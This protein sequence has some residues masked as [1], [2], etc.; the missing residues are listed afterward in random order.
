MA[1]AG[2]GFGYC[3][4]Q[5]KTDGENLF[6]KGSPG[7]GYNGTAWSCSSA[8]T[9][10]QSAANLAQAGSCSSV[11]HTTFELTSF[12]TTNSNYGSAITLDGSSTDAVHFGPDVSAMSSISGV[13]S[14]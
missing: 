7:G 2:T 1:V 13:A 11:D 12:G 4:A 10:C 9:A 8:D 6:I 5:L 14:F 3:G